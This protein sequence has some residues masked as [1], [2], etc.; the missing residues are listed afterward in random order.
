VNDV[1]KYYT[2]D[3]D[4]ESSKNIARK[5]YKYINWLYCNLLCCDDRRDY[6]ILL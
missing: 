1:H 5:T 6:K 3:V 4:Q 2:G